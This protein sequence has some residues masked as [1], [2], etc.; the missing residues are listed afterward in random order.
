MFPVISLVLHF[1]IPDQRRDAAAFQT[2]EAYEIGRPL[3][4]TVHLLRLRKSKRA[5]SNMDVFGPLVPV[6]F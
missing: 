2:F 3:S 1:D 6:F 4:M 5:K